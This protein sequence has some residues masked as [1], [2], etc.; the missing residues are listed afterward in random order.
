MQLAINI[1]SVYSLRLGASKRYE[2]WSSTEYTAYRNTA[3][4][5]LK[6]CFKVEHFKIYETY[7]NV[8]SLNLYAASQWQS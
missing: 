1:R 8:V 3:T 2:T 7:I 5:F 6:L 4:C